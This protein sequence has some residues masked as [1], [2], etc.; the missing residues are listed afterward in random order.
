MQT[1]TLDEQRTRL[2]SELAALESRPSAATTPHPLG[3]SPRV[4]EVLTG[5]KGVIRPDVDLGRL[6]HNWR[7]WGHDRPEVLARRVALA[8]LNDPRLRAHDRVVIAPELVDSA[9]AASRAA[10]APA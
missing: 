8:I 5:L 3:N 7:D 2:N 1:Q 10:Y 9:V 6:A 4:L